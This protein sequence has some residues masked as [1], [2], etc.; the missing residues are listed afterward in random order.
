MQ[1]NLSLSVLTVILCSFISRC[2]EIFTS[3]GR[4]SDGG[5]ISDRDFNFRSVSGCASGLISQDTPLVDL[6]QSSKFPRSEIECAVKCRGDSRCV[7]Y[8]YRK[9]V[10]NGLIDAGQQESPCQ[11]LGSLSSRTCADLVSKPEWTFKYGT[12]I[13]LL[14][15][16]KRLYCN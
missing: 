16:F 8:N 4:D 15:L 9:Q 14:L 12:I 13:F 1:S 3:I 7:A 10:L 6:K 2:S 11:L 5:I